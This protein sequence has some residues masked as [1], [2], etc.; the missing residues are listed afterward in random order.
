[1]CGVYQPPVVRLRR[2]RVAVAR[3]VRARVPD[4]PSGEGFSGRSTFSVHRRRLASV[5]DSRS[6][7]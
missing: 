1:R 4:S 5:A 6:G 7:P 3:P 2:H